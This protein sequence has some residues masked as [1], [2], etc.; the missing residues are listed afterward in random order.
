VSLLKLN[1]LSCANQLGSETV[2]YRLTVD[3]EIGQL[4]L[5]LFFDS[6]S[7]VGRQSRVIITDYTFGKGTTVMQT[8]AQIFFAGSIDDRDV[9]IVYGDKGQ[10]HEVSIYSS[11]PG[12]ARVQNSDSIKVNEET[13]QN[14]QVMTT[15]TLLP[16]IEGLVTLFDTPDRLIM[17][18]DTEMAGTFWAPAIAG[19]AEDPFRHFW[20]IGTNESIIVGG[21]YLV[22]D[23]VIEG[24]AL[25]LTGDLKTDVRLTVVVPKHITSLTW[26]GMQITPDV[27]ASSALSEFGGVM[28]ADLK[29]RSGGEGALAGVEV[30]EL[31]GWRYKDSLPEVGSGY[32]DAE[33]IVADHN[34]TNI[35]YAPYYGDGRILY[36]CDYGL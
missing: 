4:D 18:L 27:Q 26:N 13:A 30:P 20:G 24:D 10:S 21:P 1:L 34:T 9:L 11:A 33:W 31:G 36:G 29:M 28:V 3:S 17:F 8:S 32:D 16:G 14:G 12:G 7:L 25:A 2:E 35:P 19:P 23:A 5:P 15:V 6:L 22:R